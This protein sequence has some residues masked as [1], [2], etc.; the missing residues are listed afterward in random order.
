MHAFAQQETMISQ[1]MFNGLYL[2]PAYSGSH[3]YTEATG[4]YRNQWTGLAG[5]PVSQIISAD[6]K[7]K[8]TK[9]GWGGIL[10]NDRIGV[11]YKTD[12]YGNYAYHLPMGKG[13]L[14][15]GLRAGVSYYRALVT[16]LTVW[17]N[18]DQ[19]F[20]NNIKSKYLPNAGGGLYYYTTKFF[21]GLSAPNLLNYDP[22]TFATL[23]NAVKGAPN[24]IR[25]AYLYSGYV[26]EASENLHFKPSVLV[27][28]VKGAPVQADLNLNVLINR[29]FWVGGSYR[30]GD[31]IVGMVE[32]Q[33]NGNWRIG[34][35]YD[36]A[37]TK[38]QKYNSGSH[39]IMFSYIFVK[40][41]VMKIKSPRFF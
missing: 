15:L 27:K 26:I 1:Y 34:Y 37:L 18:G 7:I 8:N 16:Q 25:H 30:T 32:Y 23:G 21:A 17:D 22:N 5:A 41:E 36:F 10:A 35:A 6:G 38:L 40:P 9:M 31:A 20:T 28:Y 29:K 11:T 4:L 12:L 13:K 2:N 39:E 3:D 24:Y 33:H 19:V 14:S